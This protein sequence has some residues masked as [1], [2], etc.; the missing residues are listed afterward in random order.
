M[1]RYRHYGIL[2][3]NKNNSVNW[4]KNEM[5]IIVLIVGIVQGIVWGI[6]TDKIIENK[7]YKENW[8]WWGFF[9]SFLALIVAL[10][11]PDVN[12]SKP[13]EVQPDVK[14]QPAKIIKTEKLTARNYA[15]SVDIK[16]PIHVLSW[17]IQK[18]NDD[19][20]L[21][22]NFMNVSE[23]TVSAVM[24]F[25]FGFNSFADKVIID[26]KNEFEALGQD[27]SINPGG[28]ET[29]KILLPDSSIRKVDIKV[30]KVCFIDG[31]TMTC[32]E[33]EWIDTKQEEIDSKYL[34]CVEQENIQGKYYAIIKPNYWQCICG[35]VNTGKRCKIC[36]MKKEKAIA[37]SREQITETYDKYLVKLE[38]EKKRAEELRLEAERLAE[39]EQKRREEE[40]EKEQIRIQ[41]QKKV[42]RRRKIICVSVS[43]FA[44]ISIVLFNHIAKEKRY[45]EERTK[46]SN[47]IEKEEYDRAFAV[48]I[49]SNSYD[50]LKDEYGN[51]LWE[52]Q[53]ELDEKFVN[54]SWTYIWDEDEL[55]YNE[56]IARDGVCYYEIEEKSDV[57]DYTY[58]YAV[59]SNGEKKKLYS[60][61]I[62]DDGYVYIGGFGE[63]Y[64]ETMWSNGW[65]FI[66]VSI[67]NISRTEGIYALKYDTEKNQVSEIKISD[68][69]GFWSYCYIKMKDGNVV[70]VVDKD[71]KNIKRADTIKYFDVVSGTVKDISYD[72]LCKMYDNDIE[73][74]VLTLFEE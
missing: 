9:F 64:Y 45:V 16:S 20:F 2:I 52:K 25:V 7:G 14:S 23:I 6:A 3:K 30:E 29:L 27:Y 31:V 53:K 73:G 11:K 46:I 61:G 63:D 56:N 43:V 15:D 70:V 12:N 44:T 41:K 57:L 17:N 32:E 71:F 19:L 67:K 55:V 69:K 18:E 33:S 72:N 59:T 58:I 36:K 8:F 38:E 68:D 74:N 13:L 35:F 47:F 34:E 28:E 50:K 4:R 24:F 26:G 37:Y 66:T 1:K 39:A 21:I 62:Y 10:T 48:M 40:S 65:L 60:E 5:Y 49:T 42:N 54:H 22:I 51:L